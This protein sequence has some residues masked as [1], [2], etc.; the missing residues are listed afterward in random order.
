MGDPNADE[1]LAADVAGASEGEGWRW[2]HRHPRF[3]FYLASTSNLSFVMDYT[4]PDRI[5][6]ATGPLT[7]GFSINGQPLGQARV[8]RGGEQHYRQVVPGALL[9][10]NAVNQVAV[11]VDK[12]WT[13]PAD[14]AILT[15]ILARAGFTE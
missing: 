10:R 14:G 9:R 6:R 1:Y 13:A 5:L 4:V 3:R 7:L 2:A 12:F 11:D 15:F 8:E